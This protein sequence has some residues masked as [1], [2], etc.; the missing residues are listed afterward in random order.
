MP[1]KPGVVHGSIGSRR[2][3]PSE[4]CVF[5]RRDPE[6]LKFLP[7]VVDEASKRQV[8]QGV[9]LSDIPKRAPRLRCEE[10]SIGSRCPISHILGGKP[11]AY[12]LPVVLNC[13]I[14]E[15][16][17]DEDR[18]TEAAEV[19]KSPVQ[20]IRCQVNWRRW[21]RYVRHYASTVTRL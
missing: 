10:P 8:L 21:S 19:L 11:R 9:Q 4:D 5:S 15:G 12:P 3:A 2:E 18:I 17:R 6:G 1:P 16:A 7:Q 14:F 13:L 20:R